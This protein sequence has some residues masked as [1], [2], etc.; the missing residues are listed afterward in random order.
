LHREFKHRIPGSNHKVQLYPR[1]PAAKSFCQAVP[2]LFL[3]ESRVLDRGGIEV[4]LSRNP[5]PHGRFHQI[6]GLRQIDPV[7]QHEHVLHIRLFG[8]SRKDQNAQEN[9]KNDEPHVGR[10]PVEAIP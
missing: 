10:K 5:S 4:N 7:M 6:P 2:I 1:V 8:G 3:V 9:A